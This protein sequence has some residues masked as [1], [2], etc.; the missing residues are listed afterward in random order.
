[1]GSGAF[2]ADIQVS[3]S[4]A[5]ASFPFTS[6]ENCTCSTTEGMQYVQ[7]LVTLTLVD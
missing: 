4:L 7:F 2:L 1:M 3:R 5:L 6:Q